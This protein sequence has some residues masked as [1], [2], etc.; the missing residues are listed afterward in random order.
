M[1]KE[2]FEERQRRERYEAWVARKERDK[3]RDD[4]V[5]RYRCAECGRGLNRPWNPELLDD[6]PI[7]GGDKTHQGF[8]KAG[9]PVIERFKTMKGTGI[10]SD[11]VI[12]QEIEA[13]ESHEEIKYGRR[14]MAEQIGEE[15]TKA[16]ALYQ[17]V[18]S[19]TL[20]QA[21]LVLKTIWPDAPEV[22]IV[23][24]AMT[25][26]D[27]GLN[28]LMRHL[29]LIPF[30]NQKTGVVTWSQVL[31]IGATRL[32]S[33]RKKKGYSYIDGPRMMTEAEQMRI[34]GM[35]DSANIW[36]ITVVADKDGL[37]APGYG[38]WPKNIE[39]KGTEKGNTKQNMAMLRSE[40]QALDRLLPGE[41][42]PN[43]DVIDEAYPPSVEGEVVEGEAR[44]VDPRA[45]APFPRVE[46]ETGEIIDTEDAGLD[47]WLT[48]C[49]HE[50]HGGATWHKAQYGLSHILPDQT[51][52]NSTKL[53][54]QYWEKMLADIGWTFGQGTEWLKKNYS[55]TF[56]KLPP[57][58]QIHALR[59]L[60]ALKDS[61][62]PPSETAEPPHDEEPPPG[63]VEPGQAEMEMD[64]EV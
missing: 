49:P 2:T 33:S 1:N 31:G 35:F 23:K 50:K 41:M 52:C 3:E 4:I 37:Q 18:V 51:W 59:S 38:S 16:L 44:V 6:P 27:Y 43:V 63:E 55:N 47:P 19:L 22:E 57:E 24:A 12:D 21:K 5:K 25:C 11:E 15:K 58:R 34:R 17:G 10:A 7:C 48:K 62:A 64:G 54:G 13:Y 36:A 30:K 29:F 14:Y 46:A 60:K 61:F 39:P 42:P 45:E 8:V 40:R 20:P 56:S 32:I 26:R 9:D 28:P 53:F